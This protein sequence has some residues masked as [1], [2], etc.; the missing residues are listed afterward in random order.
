MFKV[1]DQTTEHCLV[2]EFS[3]NPSGKEVQ[4]FVDE[5]KN[6]LQQTP[7]LNLVFVFD[8]VE[9]YGDTSAYVKDEKFTH[10]LYKKVHKAAVVGDEKW[11][12]WW[13]DT[14]GPHTPTEEKRFPA[15]QVQAAIEWANA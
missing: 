15:G 12:Q 2:V 13:V 8:N 5:V 1:L 11:I 10:G 4:Q 7:D 9:G 14:I 6:C 3:G